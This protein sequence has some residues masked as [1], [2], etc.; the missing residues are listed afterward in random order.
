MATIIADVMPAWSAAC[1]H[2]DTIIHI[3]K[4]HVKRKESEEHG[5]VISMV[6]IIAV[7][8]A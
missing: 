1:R 5:L 7:M 2:R 8:P 3:S 6:M 4:K